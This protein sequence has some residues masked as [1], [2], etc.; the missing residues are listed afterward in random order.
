M[1][2]N[3]YF[4]DSNGDLDNDQIEKEKKVNGFIMQSLEILIKYHGDVNKMKKEYPSFYRAII[5]E[6]L[7]GPSAKK[8][9]SLV[10]A[11]KKHP[12]YRKRF[13]ESPLIQSFMLPLMRGHCDLAPDRQKQTD[14]DQYIMNLDSKATIQGAHIFDKA[15]SCYRSSEPSVP[16]GIN[17]AEILGTLVQGERAEATFKTQ[18]P[19]TKTELLETARYQINLMKKVPLFKDNF[20][21]ELDSE[22]DI[23]NDSENESE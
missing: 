11:L 7:S 6:S 21:I 20:H 13:M 16:I 19:E 23:D 1:I 14:W 15:R 2:K 4:S 3:R 12:E 17:F 5:N 22:N 10:I 9:T 8:L 18:A